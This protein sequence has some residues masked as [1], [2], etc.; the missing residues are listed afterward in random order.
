MVL[1]STL[2]KRTT[3]LKNNNQGPRRASNFESQTNFIPT[4]NQIFMACLDA[5]LYEIPFKSQKTTTCCVRLVKFKK[6]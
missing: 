2:P 5:H 1:K 3:K 6:P 4:E